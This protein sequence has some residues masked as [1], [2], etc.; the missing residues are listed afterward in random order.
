M[1]FQGINSFMVV[2]EC[3]CSLV[4]MMGLL[5]YSGIDFLQGPTV[6]SGF[7]WEFIPKFITL[8]VSDDLP[9]VLVICG[10]LF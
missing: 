3:V 9:L 10:S 5:P 1:R 8:C 4:G 7:V 6:Y 2:L